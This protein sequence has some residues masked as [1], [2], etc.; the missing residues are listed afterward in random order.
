MLTSKRELLRVG[1]VACLAIGIA[2]LEGRVSP[3]ELV[4]D[5]IDDQ[6]F[7][8]WWAVVIVKVVDTLA[9]LDVAGVVCLRD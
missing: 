2:D 5:V 1:E 4:V 7:V 6:G 8:E 9:G 3:N